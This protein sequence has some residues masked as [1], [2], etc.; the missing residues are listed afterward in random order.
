MKTIIFPILALILVALSQIVAQ[1]N[2]SMKQPARQHAKF[3]PARDAQKDIQDAVTEAK[4]FN[5]RI[6]LDVGG[7]WCIWCHRLDSL[8]IQH[9]DLDEYLNKHFVVV[10]V[11]VSKENKN[12]EVLS[13]YPMVAGYP[14]IF[15]LNKYGKLV[16]SQ[17][18]GELEFPKGH[19]VKGHDPKKV[20]AF[21]KKWTK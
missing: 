17:D 1:P 4:K 9:K 3:D 10:K 21:L 11:N 14:H 15:I 8:F 16:H 13:K 2:D 12:K 19:P 6:F 5:K 7:D 18:T 20:L